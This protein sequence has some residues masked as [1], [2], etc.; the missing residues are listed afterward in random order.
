[1]SNVIPF[2]HITAL[3]CCDNCESEYF[4]IVKDRIYGVIV[5]C[6]KCKSVMGNLTHEEKDK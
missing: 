3:M 2:V 5:I 1:M 6:N 4:K